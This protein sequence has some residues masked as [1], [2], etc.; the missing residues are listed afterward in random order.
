M[1]ANI[2]GLAFGL[3]LTLAPNLPTPGAEPSTPA[4]LAR[5]VA[6]EQQLRAFME[7][8]RIPGLAAAVGLD[9]EVF[10]AGAYG[11]ADLETEAPITA[12][13]VFPI[14]STSK[15]LTAL[16]LGQLVETG[17]L[18]LD[19]P[20]E[21][22][23]PSFPPKA[24]PV[25]ARQLAGHL[26]GIRNY[27]R[28]AGEYDNHRRFSSVVEALQ[29]FQDDPLLFEPGTRHAYSVYGFVLLSAALEGASG[30]PYLELLETQLAKPLGLTRTGPHRE[31]LPGL[32]RSYIAGFFGA[33]TATPPT[34]LSNKWAAGGLVSTPL[35][36]VRLGNAVLAGKVVQPETF[37]LLAT[38][39]RLSDGSDSGAGYG[40]GWR[41]GARKLV[42]GG[43]EVQVVHHG[44]TGAGSMS[45]LL[46]V[47]ESGLVISLQ[48]NL[49]FEPF[50]DFAAEAYALAEL[51]L[52]APRAGRSPP[53][54]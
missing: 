39:Q 12:E 21:R 6:A 33:P 31:A 19:A 53:P 24:H 47:P 9:G 22:Y 10:W 7:R 45:F 49:L 37:S 2:L 30:K 23:V 20:I 3:T 51:F 26:A 18:E 36:L 32:V 48:S 34:D 29:V 16:L 13:S 1:R 44:G 15:A 8:R 43:R 28:A 52:A 40:M 54:S 11:L 35:E 46:L 4:P 42:P 5:A 50:A 17:K 14:G 25:T 27:N 41:S 38:P